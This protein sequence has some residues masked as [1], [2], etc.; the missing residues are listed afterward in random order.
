MPR[1]SNNNRYFKSFNNKNRSNSNNKKNISANE[2]KIIEDIF[3]KDLNKENYLLNLKDIKNIVKIFKNYNTTETSI[4]KYYNF[5]VKLENF[6]NFINNSDTLDKEK[7]NIEKIDEILINLNIM[8][9]QITYDYNRNQQPNIETLKIYIKKFIEKI[10]KQLEQ[11][12]NLQSLKT[13]INI[14][15][16]HMQM[17]I[18]HFKKK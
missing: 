17:I 12:K 8:Y 16:L 10:N 14:F 3:K 2:K 5:L 4:R 11:N 1:Y 9:A 6:V 18:A 7:N 13:Y 15:R